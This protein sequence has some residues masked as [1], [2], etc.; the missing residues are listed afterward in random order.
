MVGRPDPSSDRLVI[1]ARRDPTPTSRA[2]PPGLRPYKIRARL[3]RF[4]ALAAETDLPELT[5]LAATVET[6]W[7]AVEAYLRLRVTNARTEGYNRKIKQI[8]RVAW[9]VSLD[10]GRGVAD[11]LV[12]VGFFERRGDRQ[13]PTYWVPFMYRPALRLVQGSADGVAPDAATDEET[14]A[15]SASRPTTYYW[16]DTAVVALHLGANRPEAP[17]MGVAGLATGMVPAVLLGGRWHACSRNAHLDR[18]SWV[19]GG[20]GSSSALACCAWSSAAARPADGQVA[21][22]LEQVVNGEA[23]PWRALVAAKS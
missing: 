23:V 9:G 1:D 8:K 18:P 4:Y 16:F 21:G 5:R 14:Q 19:L 17:V 3:G 15:E 2:Q 6:W 20:P 13:R 10:Q 11:R 7:P 12:A 22:A